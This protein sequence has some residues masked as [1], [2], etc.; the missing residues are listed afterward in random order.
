M[1]DLFLAMLA[2]HANQALG[3][4]AIQR[5][6]EIIRL[7]AHVDK[8]ADYVGDVV[9]VNRGEDEVARKRGIDGD[10]RRFLVADFADHDFVRIVAQDGAKAAR[11]RETFLFVYRNLRDA[12][13]LVFDRVFDGD[14]FVF[15][16]LDFVDGGVKRGGLAGACGAGDEDHAV[17]FVNEAAKS[18]DFVFFEADHVEREIAKF[19]A[20]RLFIKNAQDSVFP[21]NRRHDGNAEVHEAAFI[22]NAEAAVLRD[23]ALGDVE[24]AH[25]LDA[26][27]N[28]GVPVFGERLH[29]VLQNAVNAVFDHHFGVARL[30]VNVTGTALK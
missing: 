8:A 11:K 6:H 26:G 18:G 30:D 27:K 25:D 24:L 14:D 19:F 4:D 17:R 1:Y 20:E 16:V 29:G 10:L 15:V 23:A 5:G 21:V 22:T 28:R 13:D 12:A 9:G 2:D 7:D 3:H